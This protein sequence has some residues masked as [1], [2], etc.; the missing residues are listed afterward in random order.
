MRSCRDEAG[1]SA[2]WVVALV[3]LVI[4]AWA[5]N[6]YRAAAAGAH[7]DLWG[8]KIR[9]AAARMLLWSVALATALTLPI[10][11]VVYALTGVQP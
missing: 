9:A 10:A 5:D 8:P 6:I 4:V 11:T 3:P 1:L 7:P 2:A